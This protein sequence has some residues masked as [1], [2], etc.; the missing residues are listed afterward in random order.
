MEQARALSERGHRVTLL[1]VDGRFRLYWRR[2]GIVRHQLS[3]AIVGFECFWCPDRVADLLGSRFRAALTERLLIRMYQKAVIERGR[4]DVVYAHYLPNIELALMLKQRY[5]LP[6]V[7]IEHWSEVGRTAMRSDIV[8]RIRKAYP[9]LDALIA[10]SSAL[11]RNIR[12]AV[13]IT[14]IVVNNMVNPE[15]T[16]RSSAF[17]RRLA[18]P[19]R[20][21]AVGTLLPVKGYDLLLQAL[22]ML[23]A[24]QPRWHLQIVG[25]G[26]QRRQLH[27][28]AAS[29]GLSRHVSLVG[30]KTRAEIV[31]IL[32]ESDLFVISSHIETFGVAGIEALATGL[33]VVTTDCGGPAD[34]HTEANGVMCPPD[35]AP[36]LAEA[37]RLAISHLADYDPVAIAA[38]CRQRFSRQAVITQIENILEKATYK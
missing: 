37:I 16:P 7:G 4:P 35:D 26:K 18:D 17:H 23:P 19:V 8:R 2:P 6:T 9:R 12:Q 3:G 33:P 27:E 11:A 10:V 13:G 14:P 28:L 24:D 22:S 30:R 20:L 1:A 36:A 38:D 34:F 32:H 5:H 21:V 29:L 31:E 25:D 15:F